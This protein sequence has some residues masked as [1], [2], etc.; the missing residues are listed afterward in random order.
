MPKQPTYEDLQRRIIELEKESAER[1]RA[2][3]ALRESE[4][5]SKQAAEVNRTMAEL[6]RIIGSTLSID[7]VYEQFAAAVKRIIPFDRVM[8]GLIREEEGTWTIAY[9]SGIVV[10]GRRVGDVLALTGFIQGVFR[11]RSGAILH[12][13]DEKELLRQYPLLL[14]SYQAG[15]RSIM[16]APLISKDQVIGVIHF[17]SFSSRSYTEEDVTLARDVAGQIAGAVANTLVL[18]R[19]RKVEEAL[20]ESQ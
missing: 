16:A 7:E 20:R 13:K 14:P 8:I 15:M 18:A 11:K 6:G 5:S 2:E 12:I 19:M 9:S 10:D 4:L 17:S 3:E 1:E